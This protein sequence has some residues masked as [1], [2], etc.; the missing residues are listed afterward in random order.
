MTTL[1]YQKYHLLN[2]TI[3]FVYDDGGRKAAGYK[4]R[5]GDCVTRATAILSGTDYRTVYRMAAD[6]NSKGYG[7]RT[8]RNGI[9]KTD[10]ETMFAQLGITKIKLTRG[11][12]PTYSEAY[13]AYGDCVV[14]TS[15]H[16]AALVNGSLHDTHDGRLYDWPTSLT[17]NRDDDHNGRYYYYPSHGRWYEI[18]ERKAASVYIPTR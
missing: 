16:I 8:A 15:K 17:L 7:I 9:N 6:L 4:G 11:P 13:Q 10:Y 5:T 18:R 12:K 14:T 3:G 1:R 2:P